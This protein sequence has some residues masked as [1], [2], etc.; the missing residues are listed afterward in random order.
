MDLQF[1]D[2][3]ATLLTG[4]GATLVLDAWSVLRKHWLGVAMPDYGHV[5]RWMAGW[6]RGRWV[7]E[8]IAAAAPVRGEMLVGWT[9]HYA[10]GIAYAALLVLLFGTGWLH[11]PTPGPALLLGVATVAAPL[12]IM[13]PGMG[14]G[15]AASRTPN[16][17]MARLH[18]LLSHAVFGLG[19]Y[20]SALAVRPLVFPG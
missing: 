6:L 9:A 17:P 5:G 12:F 10:I 3:F 14:S 20:A 15:I 16:P 11:Q 18:S 2:L 8:S 19:L 1:A 4:I 7:L 13:Q